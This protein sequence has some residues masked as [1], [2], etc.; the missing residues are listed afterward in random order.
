VQMGVLTTEEIQAR[1]GEIRA[2]VEDAVAYAQRSPEPAP[3][4][5]LEDIY[6]GWTWEGART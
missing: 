5:A 6:T 3:E 4:E 1:E 2:S